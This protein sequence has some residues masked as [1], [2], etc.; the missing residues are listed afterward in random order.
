MIKAKSNTVLA[1]LEAE[2]ACQDTDLPSPGAKFGRKTPPRCIRFQQNCW[3]QTGTE[4]D[5]KP[6]KTKQKPETNQ[7][8]NPNNNK[9]QTEKH[10]WARSYICE[11]I[12]HWEIYE[13]VID[14][15]DICPS[16]WKSFNWSS[17]FTSLQS[18]SALW[19]K[20]MGGQLYGALL[21]TELLILFCLLLA[22]QQIEGEKADKL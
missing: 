19:N 20:L 11:L 8:T 10:H 4:R 18:Q 15:L 2:G 17:Q 1:L 6:P 9:K 3:N 7:P 16:F 12:K 22:E 5:L 13:S 14:W 21:V